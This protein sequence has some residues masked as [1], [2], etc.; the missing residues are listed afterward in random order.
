MKEKKKEKD[1][2]ERKL[3]ERTSRKVKGENNWGQVK[4]R[5]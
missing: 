2:K 4:N 5:D 3:T 1:K